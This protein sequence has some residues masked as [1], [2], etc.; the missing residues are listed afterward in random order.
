[1]AVHQF[2]QH[3]D[4]RVPR[5]EFISR[6]PSISQIKTLLCAAF[7]NSRIF[8]A[9]LLFPSQFLLR[10][11]HLFLLLSLRIRCDCIE[12]AVPHVNSAL[13]RISR[14]FHQKLYEKQ[15]SN[16]LQN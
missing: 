9:V 3:D 4:L 12:Y 7:T 1:M 15:S 10:A 11:L 13:D 2:A 16:S 8:H 6:S 14:Q 5:T